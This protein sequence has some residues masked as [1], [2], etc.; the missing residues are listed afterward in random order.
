MA[1]PRSLI[2]QYSEMVEIVKGLEAEKKKML[3]ELIPPE[4]AEKIDDINFEYAD[5]IAK[6]EDAIENIKSQIKKEVIE[7]GHTVHGDTHM[8]VYVAGKNSWDDKFLMGLAVSLPEILSARK[9]GAP[10]VQ[11]REIK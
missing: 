11:M 4:L 7:C 9:E 3:R 2:N 5:K 10:F 6:F 8:A 1:N